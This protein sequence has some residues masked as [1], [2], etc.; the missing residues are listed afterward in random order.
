MLHLTPSIDSVYNAVM[1]NKNQGNTR[2]NITIKFY[3]YNLMYHL[4]LTPK[5]YE[6]AVMS[7]DEL[8]L[9]VLVVL[10]RSEDGV[11]GIP[12]GRPRT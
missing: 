12:S 10:L 4:E 2:L 11:G 5:S 3:Q 6:L 7:V 9:K 8:S 1:S